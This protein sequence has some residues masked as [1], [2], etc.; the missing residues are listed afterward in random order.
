MLPSQQSTTII[1]A[2]I[3]QHI[4]AYN[5]LNKI[6]NKN[7]KNKNNNKHNH[8]TPPHPRRYA[9][10]PQQ[11][12]H[13]LQTY[14]L[15]CKTRQQNKNSMRKI[16]REYHI[17]FSTFQEHVHK[18]QVDD[19]DTTKQQYKLQHTGQYIQYIATITII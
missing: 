9:Y 15:V 5:S 3:K 14:Q 19:L 8:G 2:N 16:A 4:S 13:A 6:S 10:T 11:L 1:K 17:P 12:C 7:N 18:L